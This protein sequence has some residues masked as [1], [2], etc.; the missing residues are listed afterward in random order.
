MRRFVT[1]IALSVTSVALCSCDQLMGAKSYRYRVTVEIETP[2]GMRSG[3]N[4]WAVRTYENKFLN[5]NLVF[6]V[7]AEAVPIALPQGTVFALLRAQDIHAPGEFVGGVVEGHVYHHPS[8]ALSM[9]KNWSENM[10][11]IAKAKPGFDLDP[12]EYPLLV[13]FRD[14]RD[15]ASVERVDPDQLSDAFGSELKLKRIHVE[16]TSDRPENALDQLLPW[17]KK[18]H[19]VLQRCRGVP[20]MERPLNCRLTDG[21]FRREDF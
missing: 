17:L 6:Q 15:P 1:R 21:D 20:I 19:G 2:Q 12:D 18:L 8:P 5:D 10:R 16:V 11:R 7:R 14:P 13:R 9:T 3:S 4:V